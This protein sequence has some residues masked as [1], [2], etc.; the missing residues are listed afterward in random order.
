MIIFAGTYF[1]KKI[2]PDAEPAV[3]FFTEAERLKLAELLTNMKPDDDPEKLRAFAI[4]PDT[5]TWAEK[6]RFSER[7]ENYAFIKNNK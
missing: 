3:L 6:Q 2:Q 1:K 4:M 5:M 7:V